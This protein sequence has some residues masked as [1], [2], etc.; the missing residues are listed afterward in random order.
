MQGQRA[1]R[2]AFKQNIYQIEHIYTYTHI[3]TRT[4]FTILS[5]MNK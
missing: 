1:L 5:K 2:L 3:H 4:V